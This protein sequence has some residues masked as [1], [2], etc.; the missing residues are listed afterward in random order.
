MQARVL[1]SARMN[2]PG[3]FPHFRRT[4]CYPNRKVARTEECG[5]TARIPNPKA[6]IVRGESLLVTDRL[7]RLF[8]KPGL[9]VEAHVMPGA[10]SLMR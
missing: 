4:K 9:P 10:A 6:M 1:T 2:I 8:P 3:L 5:E 7:N